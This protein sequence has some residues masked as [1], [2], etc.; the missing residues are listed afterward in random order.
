MDWPES[1]ALRSEIKRFLKIDRGLP[2][3]NPIKPATFRED[4][5]NTIRAV[6]VQVAAL[7]A[8][9]ALEALILRDAQHS[10]VLELVFQFHYHKELME[11]PQ[12]CQLV[13]KAVSLLLGR[14]V[15]VICR[16]KE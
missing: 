5:R 16:L 13:E 12:N 6:D 10:P 11:K 9:P 7:L 3:L 15:A 14:K 4:L 2:P 1:A 8:E